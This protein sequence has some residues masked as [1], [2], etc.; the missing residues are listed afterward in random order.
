MI[1]VPGLNTIYVLFNLWWG[2]LLSVYWP[3]C[4]CGQ[5]LVLS[6]SEEFADIKLR[7]SE[8]RAL[9]T[10]NK[11]KNLTTIRHVAVVYA[12]SLKAMNI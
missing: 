6:K 8:K 3:L 1:A 11:D 2:C 10:L 4:A 7:V 5:L 9:N 12:P